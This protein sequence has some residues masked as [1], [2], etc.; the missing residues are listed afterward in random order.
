M[1]CWLY[2]KWKRWTLY[3]FTV[4]L[5]ETIY[6]WDYID[7]PVIVVIRRSSPNHGYTKREGSSLSVSQL[8]HM[9]LTCTTNVM[10]CPWF[11]LIT[12]L[13]FEACKIGFLVKIINFYAVSLDGELVIG[14][15]ECICII[16][17]SS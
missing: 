3:R 16:H 9:L 12:K 6:I 5:I 13:N 2:Y 10:R 17:T 11:V 14:I 1:M 8:S 4:L 7:I 15:A